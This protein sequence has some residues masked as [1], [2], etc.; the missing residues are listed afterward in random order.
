MEAASSMTGASLIILIMMY[1]SL[2]FFVHMYPEYEELSKR[3]EMILVTLII[4]IML[5]G[6]WAHSNKY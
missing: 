5:L 1:F 4:T 2:R 3:T 6:L